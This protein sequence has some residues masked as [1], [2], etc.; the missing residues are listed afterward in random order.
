MSPIVL[1][2]L[3]SY[4]RSCS[5]FDI[6]N[7]VFWRGVGAE[8]KKSEFLW[9]APDGTRVL[10]IHLAD[11]LGY[12]NARMMPHAAEEFAKRVE[13]LSAQILPKVTTNTLLFM[14]GSD[15]QEPQDRLPKQSR[16]QMRRLSSINPE[17]EKILAHLISGKNGNIPHLERIH[18]R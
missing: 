12:S 10:V 16:P 6:D 17:H 4:H 13:F 2:I 5:G 8:A 7:A 14:N 3:R 1:A 15:H 11:P 18:V 9:A